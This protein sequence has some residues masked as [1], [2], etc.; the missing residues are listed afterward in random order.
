MCVNTDSI[1]RYS[2]CTE[3]S[4]LLQSSFR[5]LPKSRKEGITS[6]RQDQCE[7]KLKEHTGRDSQSQWGSELEKHIDSVIP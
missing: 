4:L 1:H 7:A 2:E 6:L 5:K 3:I